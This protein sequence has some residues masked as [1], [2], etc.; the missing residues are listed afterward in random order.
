MCLSVCRRG[1]L[2]NHTRDL[3]Q[4]FCACCLCPWLGP[5]P[6]RWRWAASPIG[7]GRG[8]RECTARAKCNLRLPC[9]V[10]AVDT[11]QTITT[12]VGIACAVLLLLVIVMMVFILV[13]RYWKPVW[14]VIV[15]PDQQNTPAVATVHRV[16][17]NVPPL[18]CYNFDAHEW[19]LIYFGRNVTDKVGKKTLY[20]A[21]SSNLCFCTTWQ[22]AETRKSHFTQLDCVTH[23]HLVWPH[24]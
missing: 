22:N 10:C 23:T 12:I 17:Q 24:R 4:I 1:Y 14:Q 19:I 16:S 21:T 6:A 15:Q 20:Y 5:P 3:Y 18:A 13:T 11:F 8:W 2:R 7:A 9:C